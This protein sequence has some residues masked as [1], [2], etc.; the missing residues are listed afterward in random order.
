[1]RYFLKVDS[2][3]NKHNFILPEVRDAYGLLIKYAKA[4]GDTKE[5]LY[6]NDVILDW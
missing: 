6:F 5:Q 2:V 1:M 4:K 3:F